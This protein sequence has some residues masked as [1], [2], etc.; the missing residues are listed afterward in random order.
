M[1]RLIAAIALIGVGIFG[2]AMFLN[3]GSMFVGLLAAGVPAGIF[4]L[5][6]TLKN[7][8]VSFNGFKN[9]KTT[10]TS[11]KEPEINSFTFYA[12][13]LEDGRIKAD[14]L[15]PEYVNDPDGVPYKSRRWK[16][17]SF[18]LNVFDVEKKRIVSVSDILTDCKYH[19]P[20]VLIKAAL[21]PANTELA[22]K[23]E[24]E[25]YKISAWLLVVVIFIEF[26]ALVIIP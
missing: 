10:V 9:L 5:Y 4:L 14:V 16:G 22:K 20:R 23:I 15:K 26:L 13:K 8:P 24:D 17:V 18:Y 1:K 2:G 7:N 21:L 25:K 11:K 19:D 3:T 6:S 12:K